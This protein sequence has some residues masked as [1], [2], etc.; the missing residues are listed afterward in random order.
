MKI[1]CLGSGSS[2][3]CYILTLE[4]GDIFILEAGVP[5]KEIKKALGYRLINVKKVLI[6]H[7][8]GDHSKAVYDMIED[9]LHIYAS[10]GTLEAL[11]IKGK[12]R[13]H[14]FKDIHTKDYI[15]KGYEAKHNAVEPLMFTI[16]DKRTRESLVFITDSAYTDFI[17]NGFTYYLVESNY[18]EEYLYENQEK[19][20]FTKPYGHM[21]LEN[22][23]EMFKRTDLSKCMQ[24]ILLHVSE[25]NGDPLRMIEE[26]KEVTGCNV[27]Y[28]DKGK[29]WELSPNPF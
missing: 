13:V 19:G 4:N 10:K 22:V 1:E 24:I 2:G 25:T 28:A 17:F 11:K 9:G 5:Y 20:M 27:D 23:K 14:E 16:A 26:V 6:T 12:R 15:I 8:H 7:E 21:H 3:N 18:I 29:V